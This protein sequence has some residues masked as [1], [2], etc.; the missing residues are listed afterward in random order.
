MD[1]YVFTPK[2]N[3]VPLKAQLTAVRGNPIIEKNRK[4]FYLYS[5]IGSHTKNL[6]RIIYPC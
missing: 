1:L 2:P 3:M 4:C 6:Q 5:I